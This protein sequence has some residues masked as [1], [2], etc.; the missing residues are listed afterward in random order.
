M[1]N[2]SF[3]K[4]ITLAGRQPS[5]IEAMIK[6]FQSFQGQGHTVNNYGTIWKVLS[7]EIH[8]CNMKALLLLERKL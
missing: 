6:V 3:Q 8:M 1:Y 5:L 4:T 7:Q 2:K